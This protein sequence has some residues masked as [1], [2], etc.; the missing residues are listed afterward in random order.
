M[1]TARPRAQV[2]FCEA[3]LDLRTRR[4]CDWYRFARRTPPCWTCRQGA[5]FA[6][7]ASRQGL[8][9]I[10]AAGQSRERAVPPISWRLRLS[11]QE[12]LM[13]KGISSSARLQ[14][15][16]DLSNPKTHLARPC[17]LVLRREVQSATTLAAVDRCQHLLLQH[18]RLR[19]RPAPK[20]VSTRYHIPRRR[21]STSLPVNRSIAPSTMNSATQTTLPDNAG[22]STPMDGSGKQDHVSSLCLNRR[23]PC[24]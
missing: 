21:R 4:P 16:D 15:F 13:E 6:A 20:Q 3:A 22:Q 8:V 1:R 14:V 5:V 17:L 10:Q 23:R 12:R 2:G 18:S 24:P 11:D 19:S 9:C 7:P